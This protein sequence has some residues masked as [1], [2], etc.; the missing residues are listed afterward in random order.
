MFRNRNLNPIATA[1]ASYDGQMVVKLTDGEELTLTGLEHI[2]PEETIGKTLL[3]VG[4]LK[5]Q[6]DLAVTV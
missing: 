3:E 1:T 2:L 5:V 6:R 4:S